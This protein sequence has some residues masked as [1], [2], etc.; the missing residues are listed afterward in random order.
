MRRGRRDLLLLLGATALS[1]LVACR[2]KQPPPPP[3]PPPPPP[4]PTLVSMAVK[5]APDVNP[6]LSGAPQPV[7]VRVFQL[8]SPDRLTQATYFQLDKDPKAALADTFKAVDEKVLRPGETWSYRAKPDDA[9]RFVGVVASYQDI[10]HASWRALKDIQRNATTFL[11]ADV[12]AK[13]VT[14][15]DAPP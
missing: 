15:K 3:A 5:A 4:P 10:D 6:D 14:I 9:V 11:D 13:A 1:P 2:K 12:G 7:R 8:T